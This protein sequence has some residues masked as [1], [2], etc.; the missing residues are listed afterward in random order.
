MLALLVS[1]HRVMKQHKAHTYCTSTPGVDCVVH[2]R[3]YEGRPEKIGPSM[4]E[5]E[6]EEYPEVEIK[7]IR[8]EGSDRVVTLEANEETLINEI[9]DAH[10]Y[11]FEY[12][13]E[14]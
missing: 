3:Y 14:S 12:C 11:D 10:E 1:Y 9:L 2:Y 6:P 8:E 5:C 4:G 13:E 7:V